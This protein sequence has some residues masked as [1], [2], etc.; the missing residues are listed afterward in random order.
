KRVCQLSLRQHYLD[1]VQGSVGHSHPLSPSRAPLSCSTSTLADRMPKVNRVSA[2]PARVGD[3]CLPRRRGCTMGV[4]R[5]K[6]KIGQDVGS[7]K[8]ESDE[9][10]NP[11]HLGRC[12]MLGSAC[13]RPPRTGGGDF[14]GYNSEGLGVADVRLRRV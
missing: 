8:E 5:G 14:A 2:A 12:G 7:I 3:P 13:G 11:G 10:E 6:V 4:S 9:K 1:Q